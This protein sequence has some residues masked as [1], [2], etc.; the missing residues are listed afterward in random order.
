M[1]EV[2]WGGLKTWC[3]LTLCDTINRE[4]FN[5]SWRNWRPF[6]NQVE[7]EIFLFTPLMSIQ[8]WGRNILLS[9]L[10]SNGDVVV[11][12]THMQCRKGAAV[13]AVFELNQSGSGE[14]CSILGMGFGIRW[15]CQWPCNKRNCTDI[16]GFSNLCV[17]SLIS[18]LEELKLSHRAWKLG[19]KVN[20]HWLLFR[21]LMSMDP[22]IGG[23]YPAPAFL[24]MSD[25]CA[26]PSPAWLQKPFSWIVVTLLTELTAN[27]RWTNVLLS[28]LRS[29]L[30]LMYRPWANQ[31]NRYFSCK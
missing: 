12:Y 15:I 24:D 17:F 14:R 29:Q 2:L 18:Y 19:S 28:S 13:K 7:W 16:F 9:P 22:I 21:H 10:R 1:R 5:P 31:R 30:Q 26:P 11:P 6:Q 27:N 20:D 4:L 3:S 23:S 25:L 8:L